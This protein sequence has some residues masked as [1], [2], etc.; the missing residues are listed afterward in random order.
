[1]REERDRKNGRQMKKIE[2]ENEPLG[3]RQYSYNAV[4]ISHKI[5]KDEDILSSIFIL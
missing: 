1:M 5:L 4:K 3:F 2:K